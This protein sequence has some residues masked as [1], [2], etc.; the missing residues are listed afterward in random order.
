M[1]SCLT[2]HPDLEHFHSPFLVMISSSAEITMAPHASLLLFL[3]PT[4]GFATATPFQ[5]PPSHWKRGGDVAVGNKWLDHDKIAAFP[6][7]PSYDIDGEVQMAFKPLLHSWHGC[8]P[9]PAVD[10]N[11]NAG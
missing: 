9:Y 11:G 5:I 3:I 7:T 8:V 1:A 2:F 6:E 10:A 4:L